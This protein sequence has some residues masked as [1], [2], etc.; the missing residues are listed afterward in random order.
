MNFRITAG[1][2]ILLAVLIIIPAV[3]LPDVSNLTPSVRTGNVW[4]T[5]TGING[6]GTPETFSVAYEMGD[7]AELSASAVSEDTRN[8]VVTVSFT[9]STPARRFSFISTDNTGDATYA[10]NSVTVSGESE[11]LLLNNKAFAVVPS[12]ANYYTDTVPANKQHEWIDL[13][14]ND[15]SKDLGLTVYAPDATLGPYT[16]AADGRKDGRIFLDIA[17]RLNVT[18]GSW[19][20]K[21]QNNNRDFTPYSLNTYSA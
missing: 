15:P 19:F 13:D 21:V 16:D 20:F 11:P 4:V 1:I 3:A 5:L 2:G 6:T 7:V 14:W 18:A 8:G 10:I 12:T 9:N 17:S